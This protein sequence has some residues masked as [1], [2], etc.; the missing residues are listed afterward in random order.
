MTETHKR[1]PSLIDSKVCDDNEAEELEMIHRE[2]LS[3]RGPSEIIANDLPVVQQSVLEQNKNLESVTEM[4]IPHDFT[5]GSNNV[6]NFKF[7][8]TPFD[9][10]LLLP[11]RICRFGEYSQ[12]LQSHNATNHVGGDTHNFVSESQPSS[13]ATQERYYN[14]YLIV[15]RFNRK[16]YVGQ[17][18]QSIG[19]R[20]A[21][22][23]AAALRG[24]G[25][26]VHRAIKF[27]G[28]KNF[29]FMFL[30]RAR[31][32][33]QANQAEKYYIARLLSNNGDY[34]YN[35]TVGG[36]RFTDNAEK[37]A[38]AKR[39]RKSSFKGKH[40]SPAAKLKLSEAAKRQFAT[41]GHPLK[42]KHLSQEWK[43]NVSAGLMGN[44]PW[45][46]GKKDSQV[47]WNK[48]LRGAQ[49]AWNKGLH[50]AFPKSALVAA[51]HKRWHVNRGIVDLNCSLCKS[52]V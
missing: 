37:I 49:V 5:R 9:G 46:K 43:D 27:Y 33:F 28:L 22:H 51:T 3:E 14:I 15:N 39:G 32:K 42:G 18:V 35:L 6:D 41:V 21:G 25:N 13:A 4:I 8:V 44:I 36:D 11:E 20:C 40:H 50:T 48:G 7:V 29:N 24:E 12:K 52:K 45:N 19:K 1:K 31:G 17:T 30:D 23:I 2:R 34:G 38:A 10:D 47:A 26:Y 16:C